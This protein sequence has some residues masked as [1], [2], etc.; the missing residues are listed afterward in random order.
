MSGAPSA[1]PPSLGRAKPLEPERGAPHSGTWPTSSRRIATTRAAIDSVLHRLDGL[2][3]S[4][5]V[6]R[7]R[8]TA[9]EYRRD[10]E[11]WRSAPP[12][13]EEQERLVTQVLRLHVEV[14][15]LER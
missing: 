1:F 3:L 8:A 9:E 5:G 15:S 13:A 10:A 2:P 12:A 4:P 14:A 6:E 11:L 7:L